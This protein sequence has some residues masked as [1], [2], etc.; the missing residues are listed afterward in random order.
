M[1]HV[2]ACFIS[3]RHTGDPDAHQFVLAFVRQL[4]KQLGWWLPNMPVFF[5]EK[6]LNVGDHFNEKLAFELCRSACMV[7]FY[8]PLHFDPCNPYCAL[9]YQAML[10]LEEHHLGQTI[11]DLRNKGL[12]FPVV[13]R[14][15]DCL[16]EEIRSNRTCE[17]FDHITVEADFEEKDCQGR[18]NELAKQIF[19]RYRVLQ[20]AGMLNDDCSNFHFPVLES[21]RPWLESV[22]PMCVT[23][24]PGH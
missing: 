15:L 24:M 17:N 20:N 22:A 1:E 5:D 11:D 18:L 3:Y 6:G 7:M 2:N 8:S 14:G 19:D 4:K 23:P 21:I 16:P 9:E 10:K 12:I 13:F